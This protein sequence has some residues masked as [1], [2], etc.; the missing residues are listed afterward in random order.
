LP[1][2]SKKMTLERKKLTR[3]RAKKDGWR[4]KTKKGGQPK[5]P[6][7]VGRKRTR[8]VEEGKKGQALKRV[9]CKASIEL[10]EGMGVWESRYTW[11]GEKD[12]YN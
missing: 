7:W 12:M 2:S 8:G 6:I 3:E 9:K 11:G 10:A 5:C 1:E 4:N